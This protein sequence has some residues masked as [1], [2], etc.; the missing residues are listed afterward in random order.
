MLP[1]VQRVREAANQTTCRNNLHQI[2]IAIHAYHDQVGHLPPAFQ[3][4]DARISRLKYGMFGGPTENESGSGG[5][6]AGEAH[7]LPM[8]TYPGWSWGA[9]ILPYL[10]QS[11]L[12]QRINWIGGIRDTGNAFANSQV[13][14][15]LVCPS[16]QNTGTFTVLTQFNQTIGEY[17]TTSYVAC[18]GT[19]GSIGELPDKGNGLF[20][21]NSHYRLTEIPDGTSTT[22]AIGE[23][24]SVLCQASWIGAVSQGTVRTHPG[25][26]VFVHGIEE[27]STAVMAR[28]GTHRL[29]DVYSEIYDF[30]SPHKGVGM[31]LF[32]DGSVRAMS[33]GTSLD[34]W[35]ALAT[36][37]GGETV[38]L[39]ID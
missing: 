10:E 39:E 30:Y 18:Y 4:D 13:V 21:R 17:A 38:A 31:F 5:G 15:T 14:K 6:E 23:R 27:P 12:A 16:D 28:T 2:G 9:L 1:A 33:C 11:A 36:R 8:L 32:A 20:F 34:V 22:L 35:S 19:G 7:W 29:N 3:F 25:A 24:G 37:A 26:P